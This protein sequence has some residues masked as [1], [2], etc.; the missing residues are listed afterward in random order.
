MK[1][2]RPASNEPHLPLE[3][4]PG[5]DEATNAPDKADVERLGRQ[6][7][8]VFP[9]A[10]A[11]VTFVFA[12]LMS[13][14]MSEYTISGFN[15]VLPAIAD[16]LA[17]P[18]AQRTWPADVPNLTTAALLLPFARLCDMYGG[19]AV[20]VAGHAWLLAWSLVSGFSRG[21]V[22]LI[23]CRAMQGV[24]AGAFLPAS[25]AL[26]GQAYRPGPR[27]NFIYSLYGASACIGFYFGIF[28]GAV[29]GQL[30]DWRWFFWVGAVLVCVA[31][32]AGAFSIPPCLSTGDPSLRMDWWG[33]TTIVPG[34]V[35][36]VYALTDGGSAPRGWRTPYIYVTFV[37]GCLL[38]CAAVYVQG[39]VSAQ[40]LL[41]SEV[42]R[43]RG[44]T[45]LTLGLFCA[46]GVIGLFMF[47]VSYYSENVLHTTPLQTAAWFTPMALGGIVLA[48]TGG[49]VLHLLPGRVLLII[50]GVGFILCVLLFALLP[51]DFPS[52]NSLYWA[53]VFPSMLGATIGV[54][55][56][57]NVTNI[58][59]T[60]SLPNRLQAT[61]GAVI[62]SLLYL[63]MGFWLAVG[64][65][66]VSTAVDRNGDGSLGLPEQYRIGFWTGVGLAGL[67]ICLMITVDVGQ[68]VADMTA[69]EKAQ[70]KST[71]E[72]GEG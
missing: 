7:P 4:G 11:E 42:F 29:T 12:V 61:A 5:A 63:G 23:V 45:R 6:R 68:A 16:A 57:F 1:A 21:P 72:V 71:A 10:F 52:I 30:L 36:V 51:T 46:Y 14:V 32:L 58:F 27:K 64:E 38:L 25:L 69:D 20:F 43:P 26:L 53:Y 2:T 47:Y 8:H 70:A 66:V 9:T 3:R 54:D 19:R 67:A 41:P 35:L 50:S 65:L 59:I 56:A 60:T 34:L 24:G 49:L 44:M 18:D 22:M 13:M 62:N 37:I 40:P 55:I 31:V 15:I 39:W 33:V 17:I 28:M 48:L